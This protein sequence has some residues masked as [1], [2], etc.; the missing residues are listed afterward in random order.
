M[1]AVV[2]SLA[3]FFAGCGLPT[4]PLGVTR[5]SDQGGLCSE[6]RP[7][8][9]IWRSACASATAELHKVASHADS[10]PCVV[11]DASMVRLESKTT[12]D[13]V[14][15]RPN[16]GEPPRHRVSFNLEKSTFHE[17][18]PYS[19]VYGMHPR[20]FD[21]G[22]SYKKILKASVRKGDDS[23]SDDDDEESG[24]DKVFAMLGAGAFQF[25]RKR[26]SKRAWSRPLLFSVGASFMMLRMFG[27]EAC[28][29]LLGVALSSSRDTL[30]G[31]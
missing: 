27:F 11:E 22:R 25:G 30:L 4:L 29:E 8:S 7:S 6:D 26:N 20:D 10:Q 1:A 15:R 31:L 17:I 12:L 2:A 3:A 5:E 21:F 13:D 23:D 9:A 18:T 16:G 28:V 14:R 19:E 24:V